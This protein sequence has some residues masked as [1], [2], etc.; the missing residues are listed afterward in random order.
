MAAKSEAARGE[1]CGRFALVMRMLW[2]GMM[3]NLFK[4]SVWSEPI[5]VMTSA[6][7]GLSKGLSIGFFCA[8][9]SSV[10]SFLG[11][12]FDAKDGA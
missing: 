4:T 7:S 1:V 6:G 8:L 11:W 12:G 5:G 10:S 2:P 3:G 9:A